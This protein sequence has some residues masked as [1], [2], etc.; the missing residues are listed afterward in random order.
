[1]TVSVT[2]EKLVIRKSDGKLLYAQGDE[3]FANILLSFL[4][5]PLGGI[6]G[7]L[8]GSSL[9]SIDALHNSIA[10]LDKYMYFVSE[11]AKERIVAPQLALQYSELSKQILSTKSSVRQ[12]YYCYYKPRDY[13]IEGYV[14]GP[15]IFVATDDLVITPLSPITLLNL[16]NSFETPFEDLKEKVVT[17]GKKE[18]L[19]IL[20]A[21]LTSTSALSNGLAHLITEVKEVKEEI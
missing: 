2:K 4:T 20:K 17:I 16:L 19:S 9:G 14:K 11:E 5:S 1:M 10:D 15:R 18:C 8:R 6:V 12:Y 13:N 21:A 3:D 7:L